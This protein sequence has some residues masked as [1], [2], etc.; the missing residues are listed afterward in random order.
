MKISDR[1]ALS[2]IVWELHG[3]IIGLDNIRIHSPDRQAAS[4]ASS[5]RQSLSEYV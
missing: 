5:W 1:F 2:A 3:N 4:D